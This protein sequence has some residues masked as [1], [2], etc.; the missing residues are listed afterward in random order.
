VNPGSV[1]HSNWTGVTSR[2][3]KLTAGQSTLSLIATGMTAV[4]LWHAATSDTLLRG[5]VLPLNSLDAK[6]CT[7]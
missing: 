2:R 3:H 7:P 4:L 5:E 1:R 6:F